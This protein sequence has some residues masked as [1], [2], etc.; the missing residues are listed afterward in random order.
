M[1]LSGIRMRSEHCPL[2]DRFLLIHLDSLLL[3][4]NHVDLST[5]G[6]SKKFM[7]HM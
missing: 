1:C 3:L 5:Y 6:P 4:H 2:S 7:L